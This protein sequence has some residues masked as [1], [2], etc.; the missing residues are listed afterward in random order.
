MK[1]IITIL[2]MSMLSVLALMISDS[3][4]SGVFVGA[5]SL[6]MSDFIWGGKL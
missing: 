2:V 1:Y 6:A 4:L 5:F 3:F